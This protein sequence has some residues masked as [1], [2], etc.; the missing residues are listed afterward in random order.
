SRARRQNRAYPS[1]RLAPK[2]FPASANPSSTSGR[3]SAESGMDNRPHSSSSSG[4]GA[5]GS[6]TATFNP[7]TVSSR[8]LATHDASASPR[9]AAARDGG[10][11]PVNDTRRL[12]THSLVSLAR[13]RPLE[14]RRHFRER[15]QVEVGRT[16]K[17]GGRF[18]HPS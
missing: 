4:S 7:R 9:A 6:F 13:Q 17:M 2:A 12:R 8:A 3:S 18:A 11:E 10:E 14:H 1:F 5:S 15:V 16:D